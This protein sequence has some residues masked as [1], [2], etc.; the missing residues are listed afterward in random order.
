MSR[1][2]ERSRNM[3]RWLLGLSVCIL[4]LSTSGC[5]TAMSHFSG[6]QPSTSVNIVAGTLDVVTFPLQVVFFGP[7]VVE[8]WVNEN[9][10]EGAR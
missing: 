2:K 3:N 1:S 5:F 4:A 7:M 9:T 10:G 6:A 8:E